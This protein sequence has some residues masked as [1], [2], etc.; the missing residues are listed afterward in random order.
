MGVSAAT[1]SVSPHYRSPVSLSP[2]PRLPSS[3]SPRAVDATGFSL[4]DCDS[5]QV[6]NLLGPIHANAARL[7]DEQDRMGIFFVFQ[8]LSIRTEGEFRLKVKLL[9]VAPIGARE[10]THQETPVLAEA[11][12]NEFTVYPPKK[13]PGV[14]GTTPLSA[15]FGRQGQRFPSRNRPAREDLELGHNY[16][17]GYSGGPDQDELDDEP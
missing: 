9:T 10:I 13:F 3:Q 12:S 1:G 17:G 14:P 11:W 8:D 5:P 15:T 6:N 16:D 2:S 4:N 7:L